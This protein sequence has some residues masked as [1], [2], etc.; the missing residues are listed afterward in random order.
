MRGRILD[1]MRRTFLSCFNYLFLLCFDPALTDFDKC[2]TLNKLDGEI[3]INKKK[4]KKGVN[5]MFIFISNKY[6][7]IHISTIVLP[8]HKK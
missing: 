8:Y 5:M 1:K 2:S 6:V 7:Y 3:V 4:K